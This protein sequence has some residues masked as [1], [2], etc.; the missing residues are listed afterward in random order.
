ERAAFTELN[1]RYVEKFGFPFIIAVKGRTKDDI[2]A[3]FRTRIDN[4][5][6]TEFDTACRQVERIALL[7]LKDLLPS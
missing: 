1:T 2:L 4:D 7:R 6:A 5:R 3:A